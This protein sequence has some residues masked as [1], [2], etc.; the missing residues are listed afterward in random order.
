MDPEVQRER[1]PANA[2][3]HLRVAA[4]LRRVRIKREVLHYVR[5]RFN[6]VRVSSSLHVLRMT[7]VR[8]TSLDRAMSYYKLLYLSATDVLQ[9]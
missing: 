6:M 7:R 9:S 8:A 2:A 3:Q 4:I 1:R 5:K